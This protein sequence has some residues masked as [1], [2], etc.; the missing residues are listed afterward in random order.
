MKVK[1]LP[2]QDSP[3]YRP[4]GFLLTSFLALG[5]GSGW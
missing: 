4:C 2:G 3:V 1:H 5:Y